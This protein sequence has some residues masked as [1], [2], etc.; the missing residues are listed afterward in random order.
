MPGRG[1]P[2]RGVGKGKQDRI[3]SGEIQDDSLL[4]EDIK[5]G[6]IKEID[7]DSALQ[8]KVNS[9]G[10]GH[11][12]ED[13]G[14]PLAQRP[15][16]NFIGNGVVASDDGETTNVTITQATP[17]GVGYDQVDEEGTPLTKR[18]TLRF[19]GELI[20]AL[21]SES[22]TTIQVKP[23]QIQDEG[24]NLNALRGTIDF[25]GEGVVATDGPGQ[26]TTVTIP[27]A[28][29]SAFDPYSV[30]PNQYNYLYDDFFYPDPFG[31]SPNWH[32]E[33]IGV[34]QFVAVQSAVGGQILQ[35]TNSILNAVSG[36]RTCAGGLVAVDLAKK[37]KVVWTVK[38]TLA[39]ADSAQRIGLFAEAL[40]PSGTFPFSSEP[41]PNIW[42]AHDGSGNWLAQTDNQVTPVSIDTGVAVVTNVFHVFEISFDPAGTPTL[43]FKIDGSTVATST[44][45]IP[46]GNLSAGIVIQTGIVSTKRHILDTCLIVNDR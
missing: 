35:D 29:V 34:E 42:F 6:T 21:D 46:T 5:D 45:N 40:A 32:F 19:T 28:G 33:I 22:T 1:T 16:M 25:V 17:D 30:D 15:N 12:I 26:K 13:E 3:G 20:T 43:T 41:N 38:T 27:G 14:T 4:S 7:L 39:I 23:I 2:W 24:V 8:A 36:I 10:G 31:T 44:A 37:F 11:V 9:G 18:S